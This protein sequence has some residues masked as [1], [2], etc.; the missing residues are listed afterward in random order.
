MK[1]F[2]FFFILLIVASTSCQEDADKVISTDLPTEANQLFDLSTTWSES[3]YFGLLSFDEYLAMDSTSSLPGC[4][5]LI[6]EEDTR[7]VFLNFDSDIECGQTGEE[8]RS[9]KIVLEYALSDS[10]PSSWALEYDDYFYNGSSIRGIR[11]FKNDASNQIIESFNPL[12]ITTEKELTSIFSG[13]L[14]HSGGTAVSSS[15][16]FISGG[17]LHGVNPAGR[18]FK[19]E[20]PFDRLMLSSCFQENKLIPVAGSEIWDISRGATKNVTYLLE[21]ELLDSC[22]VTANV[23]LPDGRTLLLN[24]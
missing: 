8:K 1:I 17:S 14:K 3:L 19:I 7:K 22:N 9:G 23:R 20:I 2:N 24:P 4:P 11:N 10:D 13:D 16:G 21:Y 12:T 5:E 15:I 6:V 18:D